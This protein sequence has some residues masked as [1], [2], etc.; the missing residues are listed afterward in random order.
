LDFGN[1]KG[2][3]EDGYRLTGGFV[4]DKITI[5]VDKDLDLATYTIN[6]ELLYSELRSA[7]VDYYN[8]KLTKYIIWDFSGSNLTQY[9]TGMKA[10]DLASLVTRLG[11]ARPGGFD[12]LIVSGVTQYGIARMYTSFIEITG[13]NSSILKAMVFTSKDLAI[14][15]IRKKEA[16]KSN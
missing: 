10:W 1:Y 8:G 15:W 6:G 13:H 14:E 11:K 2:L 3:S 9:I 16:I 5:D 12:L 4:M 7:V